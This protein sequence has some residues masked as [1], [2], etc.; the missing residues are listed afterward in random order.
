MAE[1]VG[2]RVVGGVQ[3][4]GALGRVWVAVPW[5]TDA[6]VCRP[7]PECRCLWL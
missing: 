7:I 5:W 1:P 4:V 2:V 3:G 6:G